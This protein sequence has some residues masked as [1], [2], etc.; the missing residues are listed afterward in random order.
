MSQFTPAISGP[1]SATHFYGALQVGT[2]PGE[3]ATNRVLVVAKLNAG[4]DSN[5]A[6]M[7]NGGVVWT[8]STDVVPQDFDVQYAEGLTADDFRISTQASPE[9]KRVVQ[10][11]NLDPRRGL[12]LTNEPKPA[13]PAP[14]FIEWAEMKASWQRRYSQMD[15]DPRRRW[16][17]EEFTNHLKS[18]GYAVGGQT[19]IPGKS[20]WSK[21]SVAAVVRTL[22]EQLGIQEGDL[23][24]P[25]DLE[26]KNQDLGKIYEAEA[27]RALG[28]KIDLPLGGAMHDRFMDV[29]GGGSE[30]ADDILSVLAPK[31]P[32]YHAKGPEKGPDFGGL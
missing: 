24:R 29:L 21:D 30:P 6:L 5:M 3:L 2:H 26:K 16:D 9:K 10:L 27:E 22:H 17:E 23:A 8:G 18:E 13:K 20:V 28:P 19:H 25:T 14:G 15:T 1:D 31:A 32:K 7:T 4:V 12:P 11:G